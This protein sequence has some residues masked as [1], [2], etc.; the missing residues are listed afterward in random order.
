MYAQAEKP[1]ENANR[2]AANSVAQKKNAKEQGFGLVDNRP[3]AINFR[4]FNKAFCGKSPCLQKE[5]LQRGIYKNE[6]VSGKGVTQ[7]FTEDLLVSYELSDWKYPTGTFFP[8]TSKVE[9]SKLRELCA[10]YKKCENGNLGMVKYCKPA[11]QWPIYVDALKKLDNILRVAS[12]VRAKFVGHADLI[13]LVDRIITGATTDHAEY[14]ANYNQSFFEVNDA[15]Q[16]SFQ[17]TPP[18]QPEL[19]SWIT[20]HNF[21][22]ALDA[23]LLQLHFHKWW[24]SK[25]YP[26]RNAEIKISVNGMYWGLAHV[27]Y[28]VGKDSQKDE[29]NYLNFKIDSSKTLPYEQANITNSRV[30][31]HLIGA[32][33]GKS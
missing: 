26:G 32:L 1:K 17:G 10:E 8:N 9:L 20:E 33:L 19:G 15:F 7:L 3:I 13:A 29:P 24:S 25:E 18:W 28:G 21:L 31:L 14:L 4:L 22:L 16:R 23:G 12:T 30:Q 27:K 11:D 6:R 5:H 2:S